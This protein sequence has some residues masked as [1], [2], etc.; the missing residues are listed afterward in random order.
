[1]SLDREKVAAAHALYLEHGLGAR[2]DAISMQYLVDGWVFDPKR[3]C[4]VR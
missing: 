3:P 4:L 1:V 2:V